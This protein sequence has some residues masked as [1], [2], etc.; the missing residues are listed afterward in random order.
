MVRP[1]V[2][3]HTQLGRYNRSMGLL[4]CAG[5]D[6][7]EQWRLE[8]SSALGGESI[9]VWPDIA[10]P[11]AI[12]IALVAKPP[13]GALASLPN[14]RLTCSL[15]AGVDGLLADPS[16]PRGVPLTRLIDP[17]L[18]ASMVE[19]VVMHVMNA[20]RMA[21]RYRAQAV[22]SEWRQHEQPTAAERTVGILG[23]G[24]LGRACA[25]ALL[26][27][28][29]N[30]CGW[31]RSQRSH[32][33]IDCH[34][35][36]EGLSRMLERC[37]IVVLL[38]PNTEDTRGL[39]DATRIAMLSPGA[40]VINVGRGATIDDDALLA[41]L[42]R[43]HV[44]AAILDVFATEP[45]PPAHRYWTHPRVW[46]YPHVAAETDARSASRV[47][48]DTVRRWRAGLP[49]PELVDVGRGY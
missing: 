39:V 49:L 48:A 33:A 47:V 45:L 17:Q 34:S 19:S 12:H 29:F 7:L 25:E 32:P 9:A 3:E 46:V 18:S 22:R 1:L 41:A 16:F 8:L 36:E 40:T 42:D 28:G 6:N 44:E 38:L 23:F 24:E 11:A 2:R 13:R 27:F 31:S 43:G 10:D 35:G 14:L 37:N 4:L 5:V 21:P 30:V 15:W 26:P 20:H